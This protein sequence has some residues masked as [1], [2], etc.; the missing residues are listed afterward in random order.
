MKDR[1]DLEEVSLSWILRDYVVLEWT[2]GV[3]KGIPGDRNNMNK[4][5][6]PH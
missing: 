2:E 1:K 6:C 5:K 4:G 3:G